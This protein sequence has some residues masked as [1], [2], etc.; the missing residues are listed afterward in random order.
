MINYSREDIIKDMISNRAKVDQINQALKSR[1]MDTYNPLLHLEN[2]SNIP[3]NIIRG[4]K[5][6][7]EGFSTLLGMA[8][9]NA[10]DYAKQLGELPTNRDRLAKAFKDA[11]ATTQSPTF[12]KA[13]AGA[14][15]GALAGSR[16]GGLGIIPGAIGGAMAGAIGPENYANALLSPYNVTVKDVSSLNVNPLDVV[17][18]IMQNPLDFTLDALSLGGAKQFKKVADNI[19]ISKETPSVIRKML[20]DKTQREVNRHITESIVSSRDKT[21]KSYRALDALQSAP[22]ANQEKIVEFI[23]LN[24]DNDMSKFDRVV[25]R[26]IKRDLRNA[27]NFAI[28]QGWLTAKDARDNTIAQYVMGNFADKYNY[29]LHTDIIAHLNGNP[30]KLLPKEVLKSIDDGSK[31]YDKNKISYLTQ[32]IVNKVDPTGKVIASDINKDASD[33]F[34]T[35]RVIGRAMANELAPRLQDSVRFQ[36]DKVYRTKELQDV[37]DDLLTTIGREVKPGDVLNPGEVIVNRTELRKA[38]AKAFATS[39]DN[40]ITNVLKT[41]GKNSGSGIAVN[42]DYLVALQNALK[43]QAKGL[44]ANIYSQVKKNLLA[45]PHWISQNRVGN[46]SNNVIN[47]VTLEDY[48][49]AVGKYKDL[50]PSK[51]LQQTSYN[52]YMNTGIG[53][54]LSGNINK[55]GLGNAMKQGL[56][57][58]VRGLDRIKS[59][60]LG[61]AVETLFG[62]NDTL[63]NPAFRLESTLET[64]DRYANFIRQA[65]REAEATGKSVESVLKESNKNETLY[66]KLNTEV[67]K[68]LGDYLGRAYHIDPKLYT[69][70]QEGIPFYRFLTQTGRVTANQLA[71]RGLAYQALIN[72]P[73]RLGEPLAEEIIKEYNLDPKTYRGGVPYKIIRDNKGQIED[74][75]TMGIEPL[76]MHAVLR[77]FGDIGSAENPLSIANPIYSA[78]SD[79]A[80]FTKYGRQA[81]TPIKTILKSMGQDTTYYKPTTEEKNAYGANLLASYL[82]YPHRVATTFGPELMATL[83]GRPLQSRYDTS[84]YLENPESYS[85]FGPAELIGKWFGLQTSSNYPVR[86]YRQNPKETMKKIM[87]FKNKIERRKDY[88]SY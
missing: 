62:L 38:I 34:N 33:Y 64:V 3:S 14:G 72:A 23:T 50:K 22:L 87:K 71:N 35:R 67:N 4:A 1:G 36:L 85:R 21:N 2:Y 73:E 9:S 37:S 32:A 65:K 40:E 53:S 81:T 11:V 13:F 41:I 60:D 66:R 79:Y 26:G 83:Q 16:L 27:T 5:D 84:P 12:R 77:T 31:L 82:F 17:Q 46:V 20:P 25:A 6:I 19:N 30:T 55:S 42:K 7:G 76:P 24:K 59:G 52:A 44:F 74:V 39:D 57:R 29:L 63:A 10:I 8:S 48:A 58:T 88:G 70:I 56:N 61:G 49:D 47:G 78:L 15:A 75:R 80:N 45:S 28:D 54:S 51:L 86:E 43:P 69:A 68:A 18:G